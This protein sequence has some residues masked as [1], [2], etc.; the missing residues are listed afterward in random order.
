M[1][2]WKIIAYRKFCIQLFKRGKYKK[3]EQ[4][5][6]KLKAIDIP[7]KDVDPHEMKQF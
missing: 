5:K 7:Q 3:I 6:D 4:A 2:M 1:Q